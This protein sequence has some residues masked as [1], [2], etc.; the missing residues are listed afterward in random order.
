M[1]DP[2]EDAFPTDDASHEPRRLVPLLAVVML[3]AVVSG[4]A[5]LILDR[6]QTWRSWHVVFEVAVVVV[7]LGFAVVLWMG[8]WRTA[9]ALRGTRAALAATTRS[10]QERQAEQAAWQRAAEGE[11]AGFG[12]AVDDQLMAWELTPTERE[13]AFL[14]LQGLGHKQIA[15]R[16]GRS[17]RTVRQHAVSVYRKSGIDGRAELSAFFLQGLLPARRE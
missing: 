8:W 16:T 11:C 17:E 14:L 4:V 3:F 2:T 6:P 10:L 7:S 5:D 13:V 12:R 1:D 15:A 9:S